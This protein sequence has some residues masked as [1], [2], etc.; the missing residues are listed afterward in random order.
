M[1]MNCCGAAFALGRTD[2]AVKLIGKVFGNALDSG[3]DAIAAAC[4]LC[5]ANLDTRQREASAQLGR[6]VNVPIFY[7][8]ELIGV[9]MGL[10]KTRK[11]LKKHI[12]NV[13]PALE[14]LHRNDG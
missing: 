3:I 10:E 1:I 13:A 4:P 2:I 11:V 7:F 14:K 12:T 8:T 5:H 9:A 6:D